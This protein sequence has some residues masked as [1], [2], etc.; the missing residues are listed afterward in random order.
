MPE[1]LHTVL[2][3]LLTPRDGVAA[4]VGFDPRDHFSPE[5]SRD[6]D[7]ARSLNAAFLLALGGKGHSRTEAIEYLERMV[8]SPA[9]N[10]PA[11]FFRRGLERIAEELEAARHDPALEAALEG[12]VAWTADPNHLAER[13]A[14]QEKVWQLLF[15]EAVGIR[16]QE[17]ERA[18]A[19]RHARTVRIEQLNSHPIRDPA[20]ELLLTSNVLLTL[21]SASR[22]LAELHLGDDLRRRVAEMAKEPQRYWYD[23]PIQLGVAPEAN[24]VLYGLRGLNEAVRFEQQRGSW[25]TDAPL[26]CALSVSVTHDGLHSL[27]RPY[28]QETLAGADL[29]WLEVYVYTE[30]DTGRMVDEV[31]A[32]AARRLGHSPNA[33]EALRVFGVDGAYGRHYSFLK[34][35]A[36]Y[37]QVLV[38]P[39][40]RGTFKIDL[41]QVFPQQELVEQSGASA[42]EHLG[43]P[44]WGAQ[45]TD[46]SGQPL[47]LSMIAGALVNERDISRSL[48]T[49]DVRFPDGVP[50]FDECVFYNQLPQALS[51]EAEMMT[52]YDS[53]ELDGASRCLQ[54]IHVTGGTNGILVDALRRHRPFTPS[55][56]GRAE[57]QAYLLSALAETSPRLAYAH[58]AGLIMRHDKEAF[59]QEAMQA[60]R[61]GKLI[62]DYERLL[63]FSA[64]ARQI[65]PD[66]TSIKRELDPFTGAF[67]SRLPATV[68]MLRFAF[69]TA[70]LFAADDAS[71]AVEFLRLGAERIDAAFRFV[72]GEPSPLAAAYEQERRGWNLYYDT[73]GALEN[74]LRQ[75]DAEAIAWRNRARQL[76]RECRVT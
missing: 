45:G 43:S 74:A 60:A 41:D 71:S 31:L 34:A 39:R 8:E 40:L 18:A 11:R 46:A 68:A 52:R 17:A 67:V 50:S 16:G 28:L 66:L 7:V 61:V 30:S 14:T 73:L 42:F 26:R 75:G 49:P 22:R 37:W 9:W 33:A 12:L 53:P 44:R 19:L 20:R 21:P 25:P 48:F 69:K 35:L 76:H 56:I 57:D 1:P 36:A 10:S 51:T 70:A 27:A 72:S 32:P 6:A 23:H 13:A 24:E 4:L 15:P 62:G 5:S 47:D 38:D 29:D 63:L 2:S 64:Y 55:F 65:S 58:E 3:A 54:R 59:A